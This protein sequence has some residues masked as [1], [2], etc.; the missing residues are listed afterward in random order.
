MNR[1]ALDTFC[2]RGI[3]ALVLG[4]L[5]FG[6]LALGASRAQE[7]LVIQ[8]L[9][10]GVAVLWLLRLGAKPQTTL[11]W[12]PLAWAVVAFS[13]YAVVRYLTCDIEYA[14]RW[15]LIRI[16]VYAVLFF[17]ILNNL[18]RQEFVQ[19]IA[20]TLIFLAVPIAAW[21][22]VQYLTGTDRVWWFQTPY[23]GRGT[24]TYICPN[25]LGGFLEMVLPLALAWLLVGRA[26]PV[27]RVL[28]AY[29]ALV[30][31]AGMVVTGSRGTWLGAG[32]SL[33]AFF[34]ILAF[35]R[36]YRLPS[37]AML[38]LLLIGGGVAVS[39][40]ELFS[41]RIQAGVEVG[42]KPEMD[43]RVEIW[44]GT[45]RMWLDHPWFGVGPGHFDYRFREY[46][47]PTLQLRPDRAHNEYLNTLA[48]WGVVGGII[49]GAG[50]IALV[51]TTLRTW[52]HVRRSENPFKRAQSN[53][54]AFVLG[55]A[56]GLFALLV[57]SCLDFNLH[58]PA[59]AIVA[60]ALAALL[61]SHVRF[62]TERFWVRLGAPL[63]VAVS[64]PVLAGAVF[65]GV[66]QV[67]LV[68]EQL[69]RSRAQGAP[70]FSDARAEL[71]ARAAAVEPNNFET[72]YEL[73]EI[74]RTQSFE[75]PTNYMQLA[76]QAIRWYSRGTNAHPYDGY[77]F[78]GIGM[79]LDWL[80]RFEEAEPFF[81]RANELDPNGYFMAAQI[82]R[83]Y[84]LK[85]EYAA[86]RPWLERSLRLQGKDNPIAASYLQLVQ[87]RM[88]EAA[89]PHLG[90]SR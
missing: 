61:S 33:I 19:V 7:F 16:V 10:L 60:V 54:F 52:R 70:I 18:H 5:V 25:H 84:A 79:C 42:K 49:V 37:L 53:K 11:L 83:H 64:V 38:A 72:L 66:Q 62:A 81:A 1:E 86:A 74:Y 46:R 39:K 67:R 44:Q 35:H 48:D 30:I 27:T 65:L 14:G 55:G 21:A 82:G 4:I 87:E 59:N 76:E 36:S 28:L 12:P 31:L 22:V 23:K 51:I 68:P 73:G 90:T 89:R 43:T 58:V 75:G 63:R 29:A 47:P 32:L 80:E 20:F 85:G 6:P 9:A 78:M 50:L 88:L 41:E 34:T 71:L 2:E 15:E 24:G 69:W 45:A 57:H 77:N 8:A 17:A 26:Q 56:L 40:T 13:G 3:L